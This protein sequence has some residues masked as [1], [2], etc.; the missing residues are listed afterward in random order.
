[1]TTPCTLLLFLVH[2]NALQSP[3]LLLVHDK[4]LLLSL[5]LMHD[6]AGHDQGIVSVLHWDTLADTLL[7]DDGYTILHSMDRTS[8]RLAYCVQPQSHSF[9]CAQRL[10]HCKSD[11]V[12]V[13]EHV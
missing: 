3:S 7:C 11:I 12:S 6:E 4:A 2:D 1:M 5:L 9:C 8:L 10:A 13:V